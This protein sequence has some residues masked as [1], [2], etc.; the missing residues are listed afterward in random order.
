MEGEVSILLLVTVVIGTILMSSLL[1]C[2]ICVFRQLCCSNESR[3]YCGGLSSTLPTRFIELSI[4]FQF[5]SL[6]QIEFD[7]S[8]SHR[9]SKHRYT[10]RETSTN[11]GEL[12]HISSQQTE[13]E[14]V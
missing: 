9:S 3:E 13:I 8:M 2:Y 1:I 14:R 11:M 5:I 4:S 7:R 12:T 6:S 10:M